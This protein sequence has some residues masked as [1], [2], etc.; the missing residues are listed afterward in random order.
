[1]LTLLKIG[2][3]LLGVKMMLGAFW[4]LVAATA[5]FRFGGA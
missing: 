4:S 5:A 2:I 3:T 1:M